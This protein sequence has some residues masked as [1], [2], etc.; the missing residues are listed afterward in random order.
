[1]ISTIVMN[2]PVRSLHTNE[3][4][5]NIEDH[6]NRKRNIDKQHHQESQHSDHPKRPQNDKESSKPQMS[7]RKITPQGR[8]IDNID[9]EKDKEDQYKKAAES[10]RPYDVICGRCSIAFNNVG[11]RRF[12][13]LV[14]LNIDRYKQCTGRKQ[15]G[16]FIRNLVDSFENDIG[17]R[18][19]K[20]RKGELVQLT[21]SQI[22]QKVGH[23]LRDVQAFQE[24][25]L[26]LQQQRQEDQ[27]TKQDTKLAASETKP[28]PWV[29]GPMIATPQTKAAFSSMRSH[30]IQEY[31]RSDTIKFQSDSLPHSLPPPHAGSYFHSSNTLRRDPS[32]ATDDQNF[33]RNQGTILQHH[34]M[35]QTAKDFSQQP[36]YFPNMITVAV[37]QHGSGSIA[38]SRLPIGE[39]F[40]KNEKTNNPLFGHNEKN[41]T[42]QEFASSTT[43]TYNEKAQDN[44]GSDNSYPFEDDDLVPIPIDDLDQNEDI[45]MFE[46]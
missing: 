25:Q 32:Y 11:N 21:K 38:E 1:M 27:T 6:R 20:V 46:L 30:P 18:F 24:N 16:S 12:R 3:S 41:V 42:L 2:H 15:K 26:E 37:Q 4:N 19:F 10:L 9:K 22:R 14:G 39:F 5:L 8:I 23:A 31:P 7:D 43:N 45:E 17:I 29:V 36:N 44:S 34:S 33:A 28:K 13:I 40:P 35:I